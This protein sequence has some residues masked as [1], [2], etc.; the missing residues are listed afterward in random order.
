MIVIS[1]RSWGALFAYVIHIIY[2]KLSV[3]EEMTGA[4]ISYGKISYLF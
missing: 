2:N 4:V 1:S 3:D